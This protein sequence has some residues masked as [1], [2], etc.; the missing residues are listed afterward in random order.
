MRHYA[1]LGESHNLPSRCGNK[2]TDTPTEHSAHCMS[3]L[4]HSL[5]F[6]SGCD[7]DG[8]KNFQGGKGSQ[9]ACPHRGERGAWFGRGAPGTATGRRPAPAVRGRRS[10]G[11][12]R[13]PTSRRR[14]P[15]WAPR[16]PLRAS[17]TATLS[18][19]YCVFFL[20]RKKSANQQRIF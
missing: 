14:R 5:G 15:C 12:R 1:T 8:G 13:R 3:C 10:R 20:V 4:A 19:P 7:S 16:T 11:G 18:N 17:G 6:L 2:D 9:G